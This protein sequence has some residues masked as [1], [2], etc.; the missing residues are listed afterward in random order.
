MLRTPAYRTYDGNRS[1]RQRVHMLLN[2]AVLLWGDE[3]L[4]GDALWWV[5]G[6]WQRVM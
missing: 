1:I 5:F 3:P 6:Q 2:E 4:V